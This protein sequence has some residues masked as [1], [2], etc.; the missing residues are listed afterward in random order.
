MANIKKNFL[1]CFV[2]DI[3]WLQNSSYS[4]LCNNQCIENN[5]RKE[6]TEA[7][8]CNESDKITSFTKKKKKKKK[9]KKEKLLRYIVNCF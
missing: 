3:S 2:S 8:N 1:L 7:I 5:Q 6:T 4:P 9:H